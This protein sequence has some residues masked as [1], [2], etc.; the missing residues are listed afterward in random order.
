MNWYCSITSLWIYIRE[1]KEIFKYR[2]GL[3]F[4]TC[5]ISVTCTWRKRNIFVAYWNGA[6]CSKLKVEAK[7][8]WYRQVG[9]IGIKWLMCLWPGMKALD[10]KVNECDAMRNRFPGINIPLASSIIH[11]P[12]HVQC[13]MYEYYRRPS[14]FIN[15]LFN[16]YTIYCARVHS[17]KRNYKNKREFLKC[18]AKAKSLLASQF[19]VAH[20]NF[21]QLQARTCALNNILCSV[22]Q[23]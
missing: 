15:E 17:C 13:I 9:K 14:G 11:R 2:K 7:C 1:K 8:K 16:W 6:F 18:V 12:G 4:K 23:F 22:S 19:A 21:L 5:E 20:H 3:W 10:I